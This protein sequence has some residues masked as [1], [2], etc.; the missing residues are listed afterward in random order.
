MIGRK[1]TPFPTEN[2]IISNIVGVELDLSDYD[3]KKEIEIEKYKKTFE[4][5]K[6]D[7]CKYQNEVDRMKRRVLELEELQRKLPFEP[8]QVAEYPIDRTIEVKIHF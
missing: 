2:V 5:V 4:N 8:I 3:K 6:N 1:G 7:V